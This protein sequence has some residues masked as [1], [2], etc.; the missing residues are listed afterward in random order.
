[1]AKRSTQFSFATK[2]FERP[3][4]KFGGSLL[5]GN[6]KKSR[7]LDSKF[8]IHLV[9]TAEKS[10]LRVPTVFLKVNKTVSRVCKKHGVTIYRYANVGNHMHLLIKIP[11]RR[12]WAAF[13]RELTG[14]LSQVAQNIAGPQAG[15]KKFWKHRPFTRIVRGWQKAFRSIKEYVH[16][17]W[18]EAE[19]FIKRQETK[20][21]KDL[22]AI[23]A[24]E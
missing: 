5:K 8:P 12:R 19:G 24:E 6:P 7:P 16:L 13:I 18:L 10:V 20:T 3:Q 15:A 17:N 23:W 22:R 1:M 9:M 21:L 11:G 14:R 4:D 2:E